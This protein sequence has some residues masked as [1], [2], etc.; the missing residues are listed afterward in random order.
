MNDKKRRKLTARDCAL[1]A[2]VTALLLA[3]QL[4]LSV[5]PG[6]ELVTALFLSFV[7]VFGVWRGILVAIAFSFLRCFVFGFYPTVLFVYL[8]Y[9]PFLAIVFGSLGKAVKPTLKGLILITG[10]ACLCSVLFSMLDNVITPLW[11][12]YTAEAAKAYFYGSLPFMI[13][14]VVC[15]GISVSILFFPLYKIFTWTKKTPAQ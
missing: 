11:Y 2:A 13:P 3:S 1:I 15:V 5:L 8:I 9:Y 7:F 6:V 4:A 10:V 12:G 14:Q